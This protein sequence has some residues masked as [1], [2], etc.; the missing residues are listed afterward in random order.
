MDTTTIED[1][2]SEITHLRNRVDSLAEASEPA[3]VPWYKNISTIIA[4]A[5]F[6]FS[7]G[8]TVVSYKRTIDQDNQSKKTELRGMLQRLAILPKE[9]IEAS[10]TYKDDPMAYANI[11][12]YLNQE[13]LILSK[14]AD[15]TIKRL[16]K[17][18]VTATDY[19]A[20]ALALQASRNFEQAIERMK[21]SL[22]VADTLDDELAARR[23]LA[24]MELMLGKP[25]EG[26][27]NFQAAVDAFGNKYQNY[28][29]FTKLS[30]TAL[31]EIGWAHAEAT[32]GY[33]D[34]ALLHLSRAEQLLAQLPNGPVTDQYKGQIGQVRA[35]ILGPPQPVSSFPVLPPA[36]IPN[37]PP[38]PQTKT[39]SSNPKSK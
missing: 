26:R 8:T 13:N 33:R 12:G 16:P 5:A 38:M 19:L 34:E 22:E 18:Y 10:K 20:V 14:Q 36:T 30:I 39:G 2:R 17:S 23:N 37:L 7:F 1:I 28:D 31:T 27:K 4:I 6:L 21:N 25:G 35:M 9:N 11:S 3:K 32:A 15:D 29:Q 24:A